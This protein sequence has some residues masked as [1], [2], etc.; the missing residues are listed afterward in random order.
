MANFDDVF[1]VSRETLD[2]LEAYRRLLVKW[3]PSINLVA[4]STIDDIWHRHFSDSAQLF[5]LSDADQGALWL[6]IGSGGGLPGVVISILSKMSARGIRVVLVESDARK[7]AFLRTVARDLDLDLEILERRIETVEPIGADIVT[8]R[9]FASLS[10]LLELAE[11][12]GGIEPICLF[13]KGQTFNAELTQA[14]ESWNIT[15][16]LIPSL[17]DPLARII[18]IKGFSRA[19]QR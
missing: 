6:D 2:L 5:A 14:L 19:N 16:E 15:P 17:T 12:H 1:D 4:K 3:N 9:A 11:L 13:P 8:A 10:E 7:C 18:K